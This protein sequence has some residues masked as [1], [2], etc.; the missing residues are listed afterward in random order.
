M[1]D[2]HKFSTSHGHEAKKIWPQILKRNMVLSLF[3]VESILHKAVKKYNTNTAPIPVGKTC[4][5][6]LKKS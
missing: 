1:G 4:G 5:P 2:S 6:F 3:G